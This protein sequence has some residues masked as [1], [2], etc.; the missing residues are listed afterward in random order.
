MADRIELAHG[1][2]PWRPTTDSQLVATYRYYDGPLTGI[3]AQHGNEYV[4]SCLD[5]ENELL[6]LWIFAPIRHDQRELLE[7]LPAADFWEA[8]RHKP[9][10]GTH[11]LALV[12]ERLGI[13]DFEAVEESEHMQKDMRAALRTL[14]SR[15]SDLSEDAGNLELTLA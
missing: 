11:V 5:G 7:A 6:S 12:T 2:V 1:H 10:A 14:R 13:V 4:F 15:L 8:F 9:L 3:V